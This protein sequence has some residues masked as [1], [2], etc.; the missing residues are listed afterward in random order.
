M[1]KSSLNSLRSVNFFDQKLTEAC[2]KYV[3]F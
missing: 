3:Y 1:K 2:K